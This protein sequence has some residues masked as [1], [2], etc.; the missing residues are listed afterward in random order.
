MAEGRKYRDARDPSNNIVLTRRLSLAIHPTESVRRTLPA[1][2]ICVIGPTGT[3]KTV[4][5][6]M[7]NI[8]QMCMGLERDMVVVDPKGTTLGACGHALAA[9]G[10][11]VS[12]FNTVDLAMSDRYNPLAAIETPEDVIAFVDCLMANTNDGKKSAEGIW[13]GGERLLY[14]TVITLLLDWYPREDLTFQN[15]VR[16][17]DLIDIADDSPTA[18]CPLDYIFAEIETGE[19]WAA[20]DQAPSDPES[21]FVPVREDAHGGL[22]RVPSLMVRRDGAC[23]ALATRADGGH[24]LDAA[25]TPRPRFG[26]SSGAAARRR[27]APSWCRPTRAS[28][29]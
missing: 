15:M 9:A 13:D 25:E 20:D 12:V 8:L 10:V 27:C 14:R 3:G 16:L 18:R 1:R 22:V 7:P 26:T 2:N 5:Y 24:G 11:D 6:V 4:G 21:A 17:V 23:P 28:P 19:A 29:T